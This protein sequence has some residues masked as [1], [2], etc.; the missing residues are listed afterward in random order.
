MNLK[1]RLEKLERKVKTPDG[2]TGVLTYQ[3]GM[4]VVE[5]QVFESIEDVPPLLREKYPK[6]EVGQVSDFFGHREE[7]Y[8]GPQDDGGQGVLLV[9][10]MM[11]DS[12]WQRL[13]A[14]H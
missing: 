4:I 12:E 7:V 5:G 10:G 3:P 6:I 1:N 8:A 13:V 11:S 14:E 2:L 9:P